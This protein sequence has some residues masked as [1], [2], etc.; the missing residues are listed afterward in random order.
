MMRYISSPIILVLAAFSLSTAVLA[1]PRYARVIVG[2]REAVISPRAVVEGDA[3]FAPADFLKSLEANYVVGDHKATVVLDEGTAELDLTKRNGAQMIRLDEAAKT[4]DIDYLWDNAT[5]TVRLIGKIVAVEYEDS[6]LTA[7]LTLPTAFSSIRIWQTP[8]RI[9][10]DLPGARVGT[11]TKTIP[12]VG[13]DVS[14]IRV[15]Q[16]QEDTARIVVDLGGKTNYR[17]LTRGLSR[18][19]KVAIGD[20]PARQATIT[21]KPTGKPEI[22]VPPPPTAPVSITGISAEPDGDGKIRVRIATTGRAGFKTWMLPS[23]LRVIADVKNATLDMPTDDI[24]V[25]HSL[26]KSI[27]VGKQNGDS[28]VVLDVSRYTW[29]DTVATESEITVTLSLPESAGGRLSEKTIVLDPGHGGKDPG[30]VI[31]DTIKEKYLTL[32]IAQRTKALLEELGARVILTREDNDTFLGLPARPAVAD[33][34]SADFFIS[35]HCN[36][37]GIPDKISGVETYYHPGQPS[38]RSLAFAVHNSI[39]QRTGMRDLKAKLDTERASIGFSVLRN[40]NVPAILIE[41]GFL[42]CTADRQR[43]CD[44]NFRA[45]LAQAIVEGLRQYVEGRIESEDN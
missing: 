4:L 14:R 42:D 7:R 29:F 28:R 35:I 1:G 40:A 34:Y 30:K 32:L 5:S 20:A 41:T 16:F 23:P 19:I 17:I 22:V 25:Q 26:L 39:I 43:L 8:W 10:L 3:V 38:S 37:I 45:K 21:V 12:V 24:E 27:R 6:V 36:A 11:G 44:D 31:S 18:E 2:T 9:S 15:G 13:A 33:A